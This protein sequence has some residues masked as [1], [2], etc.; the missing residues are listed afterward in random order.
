MPTM[1]VDID[2]KKDEPE[3]VVRKVKK[4]ALQL[5]AVE[6]KGN[7]QRN[8]PVDEGGLQGGWYIAGI[9]DDNSSVYTSKKYTS[10]VNDGT[11]LYGP[12]KRKIYP[13]TK[14]FLAF[15]YKGKK[16]VVP[17]VRGIKPRRFV[18][19]SITQTERRNDEFVIRAILE[20]QGALQ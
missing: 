1:G 17:W 18:E 4:R 8:S 14:K 7:L 2:L 11:G 13:K 10:Y 15:K 5:S 16:V 20:N 3:G 9:G 19:K 12:Y 6:L